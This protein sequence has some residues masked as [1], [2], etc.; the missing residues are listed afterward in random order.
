M[1]LFADWKNELENQTDESFDGF[2]E[3]YSSGETKI[4]SAVLGSGDP[5]VK[6]PIKDL[7]EKYDVEPIIFMGFLDGIND[8]LIDPLDLDSLS[9]EDEVLLNIDFEKL[10]F[11]MHAA[12]ADYLY[13][14]S[15]W[16]DVLTEEKRGS[17]FK[18]YK[19]SKTLVKDKSPGRNDP[20][21]CGSGKKYKKCCGA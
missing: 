2:W 19:K 12:K 3:K 8:S 1:S 16:N 5:I 17:I 7:S 20:C 9:E 14:L 21:P 6:G 18:D 15:Q 13:S 4:Y 10:Y 11:N